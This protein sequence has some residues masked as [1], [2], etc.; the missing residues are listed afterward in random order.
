[1]LRRLLISLTIAAA[2]VPA[3]M[4]SAAEPPNQDDP[5]S[6]GGRDSCTTTGVGQYET[7]RYGLRWFGDYRGAV[8]GVDGADVLPRP[9]LLVSRALVRLRAGAGRGRCATARATASRPRAC[10][11]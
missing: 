2:L 4:A 6:R 8:R 10:A 5:C 1:M 11:G 9:A 7:Y 3:V